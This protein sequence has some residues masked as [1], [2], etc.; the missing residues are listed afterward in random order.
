[1]LHF[2]QEGTDI[3]LEYVSGSIQSK[4]PLN[5]ITPH[6]SGSPIRGAFGKAQV[7]VMAGKPLDE[8][9]AAYG[10]FVMN[11]Q[12]EIMQAFQDLKEGKM[13]VVED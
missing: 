12:A 6:P 2:S 13:G 10:P 5:P 3:V 11:T 7:L 8:P 4:T 1:M 9:V